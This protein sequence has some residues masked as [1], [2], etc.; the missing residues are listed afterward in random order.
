[1][2]GIQPINI[3]KSEILDDF[4]DGYG[5]FSIGFTTWRFPKN[6]GTQKIIHSNEIFIDF[7]F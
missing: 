5:W 2:V 4:G 7:P 1:M 3:H 6:G